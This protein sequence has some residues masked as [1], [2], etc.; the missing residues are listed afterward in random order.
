MSG[1][2]LAFSESDLLATVKAYDPAVHEAPLV[3]GHPKT[4]D[5]AFGW[6]KSLSFADGMLS[7]EPD[8]VDA[9]FAELVN[10]GKFKKV[11][12]SFYTPDSPNNPVPG[13]YYLR[14]VGFLGAQPPAVKGMK[15]ASFADN[16]E[17]VIEFSDWDMLS[18]ASIFRRIRELFI[19]KFGIDDA[20]KA[21]SPYEI[22][23]LQNSAAQTS[24]DDMSGKSLFSEKPD[25][26]EMTEQD[27]LKM[28]KLEAENATLA[29]ANAAHEAKAVAFAEAEQAQ[30][31]AAIHTENANFAE[32]LI[33]EGKLLPVNKDE[34]IAFMNHLAVA[35]ASIEFGE[36]DAKA[37]KTPLQI[38][39]DHLTA[40]PKLVE[41]AEKGGADGAEIKDISEDADAM[42]V[43][44]VAFTES[45]KAA[46]RVVNAAQAIEHVKN[47]HGIK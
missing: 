8:Q 42:A 9:A 29:A 10:D 14:H 20:D 1:A 26:D 28:A 33:K 32:E 46:G 6:V 43:E 16:E 7:A 22:D 19:V 47:K 5:P 37:K 41:F 3:V 13:V 18:V 4:D 44:A 17:G 24:N 34:T 38:Y 45:E 27:K 35:D 11:S 15:S 2:A 31:T 25:G 12:A 30:K 23:Y 40:A 39:K 21:I 36:G